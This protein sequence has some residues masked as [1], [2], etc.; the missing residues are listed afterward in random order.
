MTVEFDDQVG[1]GDEDVS[2]AIE[3]LRTSGTDEVFVEGEV[4]ISGNF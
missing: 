3:Y 2:N 4:D 1:V